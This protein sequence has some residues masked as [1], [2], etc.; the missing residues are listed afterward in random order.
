MKIRSAILLVAM[1]AVPAVQAQQK[2]QD[3][4]ESKELNIRA[5]VELL[6]ADIKSKKVQVITEVMQFNDAQG[7]AFWP[8]Y[9]EYDVELSR[10]GDE[11]L[12]NIKAYAEAYLSMTD[13]KADALAQKFLEIDSHRTDLRKKYYDRFKKALGSIM[14]VRFFQVETQIQLVLDLQLAANM[15]IIEE[16]GKP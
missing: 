3:P 5:Y 9:R 4:A 12:A 10:I 16:T 6:R 15:P 7:A 11:R 2:L 13:E 1:M 14:A 8:L